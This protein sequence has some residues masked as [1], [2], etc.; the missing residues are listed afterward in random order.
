MLAFGGV[1]ALGSLVRSAMQNERR[2]YIEGADQKKQDF[3]MGHEKLNP[4]YYEGKQ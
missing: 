1:G 4:E 3:L 2:K